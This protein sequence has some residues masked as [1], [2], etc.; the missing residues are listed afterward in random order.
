MVK[1]PVNTDLQIQM[2]KIIL[3]LTILLS[4]F[5]VEK[6][7]AQLRLNFQVNIGSQPVWGPVGYDH[8]EYYYLPDIDAFYYVPS[9]QYIYQQRGRWIFS[10]SLPPRYYNYDLYSGYKVVVNEPRPYRNAPA[11]RM[12][13]AQY[14]NNH[15]QEIIRNSREPRYFENKNHPDHDKWKQDRRNDNRD[16]HGNNRNNRGN[17]RGRN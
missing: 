10:S 13:Y 12:Q 2:K 3:I 5:I 6:A 15:S 16:N 11:Y 1:I 9:Q 7:N 4:G 14:R 8:V 17:R